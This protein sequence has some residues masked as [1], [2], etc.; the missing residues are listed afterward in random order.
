MAIP[1]YYFM[2][3]TFYKKRSPFALLHNSVRRM[4]FDS[5]AVVVS[6]I[7]KCLCT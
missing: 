2:M 1:F 3:H 4:T 7:A 5:K 6:C